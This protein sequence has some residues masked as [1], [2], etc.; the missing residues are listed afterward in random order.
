MHRPAFPDASRTPRRLRRRLAQRR[1]RGFPVDPASPLA[2]ED[3]SRRR[4][5]RLGAGAA[6]SPPRD[7]FG[8]VDPCSPT[9]RRGHR[10]PFDPDPA[11]ARLRMRRL[12]GSC[13][14]AARQP[15]DP[16]AVRRPCSRASRHVVDRLPWSE[17]A[18]ACAGALFPRRSRPSWPILQRGL[19]DLDTGSRPFSPTVPRCATSIRAAL[20]RSSGSAVTPPG[21]DRSREPF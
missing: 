9:D 1:R 13:S 14:L 12:G 18:R 15:A 11:R 4:S 20:A 3:V 21:V 16:A 8:P 10:S 17:A 6:S 19:S 7:R 5:Q 2:R